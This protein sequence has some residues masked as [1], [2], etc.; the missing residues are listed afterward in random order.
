MRQILK[1]LTKLCR[2]ELELQ[3]PQRLKDMVK[4]VF[5]MCR[6]ILKG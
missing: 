4:Y 1:V 3:K 6:A 2:R 5:F